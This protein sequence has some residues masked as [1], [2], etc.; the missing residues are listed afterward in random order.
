E[1]ADQIPPARLTAVARQV[2]TVVEVAARD[3][4]HDA[5]YRLGH[6]PA[7]PTG[8][9]ATRRRR[10]AGTGVYRSPNRR[11]GG[12]AGGGV[13]NGT[14]DIPRGTYPPAPAPRAPGADAAGPRAHRLHA[15]VR[16][17]RARLRVVGDEA[18][19]VRRPPVG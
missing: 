10:P 6:H 7:D 9:S 14:R 1:A 8:A 12:S 17:L 18:A 5:G 15:Q 2:D 3:V 11:L 16:R 19:D 4:A 13:A